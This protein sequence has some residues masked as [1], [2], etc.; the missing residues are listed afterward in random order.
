MLSGLLFVI[1]VFGKSIAF[2]VDCSCVSYKLVCVDATEGIVV[3]LS[4]REGSFSLGTGRLFV[5]LIC[6]YVGGD[7]LFCVFR[8]ALILRWVL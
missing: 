7:D 8:L 4:A 1:G 2:W 3:G 6:F 5:S